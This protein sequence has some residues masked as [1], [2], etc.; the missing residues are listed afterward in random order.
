MCD[1]LQVVGGSAAAFYLVKLAG[2]IIWVVACFCRTA[3]GAGIVPDADLG[4]LAA[5]YLSA[6]LPSFRK[7]KV[8][9]LGVERLRESGPT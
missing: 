8:L 4:P 9:R 1:D 2:A 5:V 3:P 6:L 7:L